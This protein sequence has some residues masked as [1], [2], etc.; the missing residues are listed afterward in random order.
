MSRL[1][2]LAIVAAVTTAT[3]TF[4]AEKGPIRPVAYEVR[5]GIHLDL[6]MYP[7]EDPQETVRSVVRAVIT[8]DIRYMLAHL[9]SPSQVDEKF[10]GNQEAFRAMAT[11]ASKAKS[12]SMVAAL[13]R[14]LSHGTWV[15][16]EN[17]ALSRVEGIPN[18]SLEKI[19]ERWFMHNTVPQMVQQ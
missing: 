12:E 4:G 7:Q 10:D 8:G 13:T 16:Q 3:T 9:I 14:Q 1:A 5:Y 2:V 19:G 18:L 17:L 11:K 15:I 6:V